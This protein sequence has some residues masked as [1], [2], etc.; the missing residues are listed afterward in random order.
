MTNGC[1]RPMSSSRRPTRP[2]HGAAI[3][4]VRPSLSRGL[5]A[6][7]FAVTVASTP[8]SAA[9]D[10]TAAPWRGVERGWSPALQA[11]TAIMQQS[12]LEDGQIAVSRTVAD[13][14]LVCVPLG[15]AFD[16]SRPRA[17]LAAFLRTLV[18]PLTIYPSMTIVLRESGPDRLQPQPRARA[19]LR[20]LLV[21]GIPAGGVAIDLGEMPPPD[22][23]VPRECNRTRSL[24]VVIEDPSVAP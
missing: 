18:A 8:A 7:A 21:A 14:L 24:R 12:A 22:P 3:P 4:R 2:A 5:V 19:V 9:D 16:G 10:S 23:A 13:Q 6:A 20:Y 11:T 1:V 15:G 17:G